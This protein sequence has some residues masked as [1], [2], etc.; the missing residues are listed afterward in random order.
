MR[1]RARAARECAAQRPPARLPLTQEGRVRRPGPAPLLLLHGLLR[2]LRQ[3]SAAAL[4]PAARRAGAR[5][6]DAAGAV[7]R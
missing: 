1:E 2:G 3:P 6:A 7:R 4:L 5:A